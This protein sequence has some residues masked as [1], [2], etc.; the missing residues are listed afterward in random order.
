M[1]TAQ[2]QQLATQM[3][4][5]RDVIRWATKIIKRHEAKMPV[6]PRELGLAKQIRRQM[7]EVQP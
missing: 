2:L 6:N 1:N 4:D 7:R 5:G 3:H